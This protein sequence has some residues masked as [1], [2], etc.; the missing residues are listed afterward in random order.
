M[1]DRLTRLKK[2]YV[3]TDRKIRKRTLPLRTTNIGDIQ[4]MKLREIRRLGS[5]WCPPSHR[6]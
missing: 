6:T 4:A 5:Q 2:S 1:D 3:E